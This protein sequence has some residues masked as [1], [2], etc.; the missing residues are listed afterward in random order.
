MKC[1]E[2]TSTQRRG[3]A[4]LAFV[5][6]VT[7]AGLKGTYSLD[8]PAG[9]VGVALVAL[10]LFAVVL[11]VAVEWGQWTETETVEK[12]DFI[13]SRV[14]FVGLLVLMLSV[15]DPHNDQAVMAC[16][17]IGLVMMLSAFTYHSVLTT[18][19]A[20]PKMLATLTLLLIFVVC[21]GRYHA[22]PQGVGLLVVG[23]A[24]LTVFIVHFKQNNDT[25]EKKW[26]S[27]GMIVAL[28]VASSSA[29]AWNAASAE[30]GAVFLVVG[31]VV[32]GALL[33]FI[34]SA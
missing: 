17:S 1:A 23:Y 12:T 18:S 24:C 16:V 19:Y 7:G 33:C 29:L 25:D 22:T 28:T 31:L 5:T 34:R 8:A 30:V 27:I 9:K 20:V 26:Y 21:G 3:A 2:V 32:A 6:F 11:F 14:G 10:T 13:A 15:Q 4:L